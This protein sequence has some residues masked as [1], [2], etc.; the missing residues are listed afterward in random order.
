MRLLL[1]P[2]YSQT[3]EPEIAQQ[4]IAYSETAID[5]VK[6]ACSGWKTWRGRIMNASWKDNVRASIGYFQL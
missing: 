3:V 2:V 1:P 5:E 6:K 4:N